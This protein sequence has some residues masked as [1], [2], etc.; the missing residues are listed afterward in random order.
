MN[1]E[2]Y[3]KVNNKY[4]YKNNPSDSQVGFNKAMLKNKPNQARLSL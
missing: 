4:Q 1:Y 3:E 2:S